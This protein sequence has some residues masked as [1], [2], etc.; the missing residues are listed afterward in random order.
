MTSG[1][2]T[3]DIPMRYA[4]CMVAT[5]ERSATSKP[6]E[7]RLGSGSSNAGGSQDERGK[8]AERGGRAQR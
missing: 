7:T 2:D 3:P 5:Q 6:F 8:R 1:E 4:V